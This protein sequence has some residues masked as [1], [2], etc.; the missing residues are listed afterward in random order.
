MTAAQ[1][2]LRE[3]RR[4]DIGCGKP[5]QKYESCFGIDVN[6]DYHPDLLHNADEGLP[7]EDNQ[8]EFIHCDNALEHFRNPHF[9]LREFLRT[10]R[11]GGEALVVVP[12][13][14]YLPLL[15]VNMVYDLNRAWHWY[16]NL[17]FKKGRSIHWTLYTKHLITQVAEDVGFQV[18]ERKGRLYSKEITL[19]L[20]KPLPGESATT[21]AGPRA[22]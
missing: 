13:C 1:A 6:P 14:Q 10:L 11:P 7:F 12:N 2:D 3:V 8:L 21:I 17:P 20:R 5:E 18:V 16:M 9:V 19:R 22:P 15:A 4:V